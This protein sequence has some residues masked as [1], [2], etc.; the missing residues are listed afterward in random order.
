V[1]PAA[2]RLRSSADF[3]AV[4]RRGS[5]VRSGGV[6]LYLLGVPASSEVGGS[7][8]APA[9]AARCGL[10]VAKSV[11]TSV[12]RHRVSRRLRAQLSERLSGLPAGARLVV[13]ALPS[14][15]DEPSAQLGRDLDKAF[16]RLVEP[17]RRSVSG[18]RSADAS[19][20]GGQR[21]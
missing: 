4:T 16:K 13:R 17:D 19:Q 10:I 5:R 6:V 8:D 21:R 3:A 14:A 1:L 7:G 12:V 18:Q 20:P 2:S 9:G 15:A 11:G